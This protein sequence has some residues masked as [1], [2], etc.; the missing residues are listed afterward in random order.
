M[1]TTIATPTLLLLLAA[2]IAGAQD[3]P[4]HVTVDGEGA[5]TAQ[6]DIAH[7]TMAIQARNVE[8][9]NARDEAV[10]ITRNFLALCDRLGIAGEKIH[11]SG[12]NIHPEYRWNERTQQ[13]ELQAY[14]VRRQF[15]VE[16][17]D[18]EKL[19]DVMEGAIDAGV[20]EVSQPRLAS[21]RER[22]LHRE[23]LALAA[24]DAAANARILADSLGVGIGGVVQI[25]ATRQVVPM[26][27][28]VAELFGARAMAADS[29]GAE[30]YAVGEIRFEANVTASFALEGN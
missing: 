28:P 24:K 7:I 3:M 21:S 4:R 8:V 12:L 20:N 9:R 16:L 30:T 27:G 18:L 2:G 17:D 22:E 29:D 23:A 11:T 10:E 15:S 25:S 26:P 19:G 14:L 5:V 6:P 13:Q 1:K